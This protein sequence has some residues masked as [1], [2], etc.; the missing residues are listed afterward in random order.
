M[1]VDDTAHDQPGALHHLAITLIAAGKLADARRALERAI[2][3]D[4]ASVE[5]RNNLGFVLQRLGELDAA[6]AEYEAALALAPGNAEARSNLAAA[7]AALGRHEDGLAEARRAV[8]LKPGLVAAHVHAAVIEMELGRL[9][10]AIEGIDAIL[11]AAPDTVE[12][13]L[14]RAD[15]LGRLDRVDEA[16]ALC[17][18]VIALRPDDGN[19]YNLLGLQLQTLMRDEDAL[20][21]FARAGALLPRPGIALANQGTLL[22]QLG[23]PEEAEA[24]L[25]RAL[26]LDPAC[27]AAWYARALTQRTAAD[28]P[29]L[30]AME[31]ILRDNRAPAYHERLCLHYALGGAWLE[32]GDGERAFAHLAAGA[33]MKRA[34]VTYDGAATE[35]WMSE[36]AAAFPAA[37]FAEG[38]GSGLASELPVFV[39]GM[40][41]SGTTLIEQILG[42]HPRVHAAGELRL[43]EQAVGRGLASRDPHDFPGTLTRARGEEIAR[44]YLAHVAALAPG[45]SR[46]VDKMMSNIVYAGLIH[47]MLP[48]ARII[49][50]QR[51]PVDTCLSCYSKLFARGQDYSYDLAELG[52]YFRAQ[53][54]LAA[55]WRTVLPP[56]I[57]LEID[58]ESVIED[59]DA[60]ARRLVAFCGLAWSPSCLAFHET[61]RPV[62]T[63]SM[64]QVRQPIYRISVG[65]WRRFRAQLAPLL[66]ALGPLAETSRDRPMPAAS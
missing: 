64:T 38:R 58:Y 10:A 2:E 52:R 16:L 17:R 6:R 39:V 41:R 43:L 62:R 32:A 30:D 60:A 28:D 20:E 1:G 61:R 34:L 19:G 36:I 46:I 42:S 29:D 65:R 47:L 66:E 31:T 50:C 56:D 7:L 26:A 55:H 59:V 53:D 35:R 23:R 33:R 8:A 14:V 54:A 40:P 21:A 49:L 9:D 44:D 4:S 15:I 27:A 57:F 22:C 25:S 63:A 13:L 48:R 11:P 18:R 5:A 12:L 3:I 51:D 24:A 45:A 37:I